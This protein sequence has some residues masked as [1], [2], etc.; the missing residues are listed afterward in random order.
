MGP[1]G[2]YPFDEPE[3]DTIGSGGANAVVVLLVDISTAGGNGAV[4]STTGEVF[5]LDVGTAMGFN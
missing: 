4:E 3:D 1:N 5:P 2:S